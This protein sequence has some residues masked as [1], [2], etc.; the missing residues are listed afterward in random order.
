[1]LWS[2]CTYYWSFFCLQLELSYLQLK[3][4]RENLNH[5]QRPK[6]TISKNAAVVFALFHL[7][8]LFSI[9][10]ALSLVFALFGLSVSDRFC[11][12]VCAL[13]RTIRLLLFSGCHLDSPNFSLQLESASHKHLNGLR[14][15]KRRFHRKSKEGGLRGKGGW[16]RGA[17]GCLRGVLKQRPCV[18]GFQC[19]S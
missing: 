14:P 3:F 8:R 7:F 6:K 19:S 9:V 18:Q 1:M 15:P 16:G 11:Q 17:G 12:T 13:F 4:F 10:F 2:F 5:H